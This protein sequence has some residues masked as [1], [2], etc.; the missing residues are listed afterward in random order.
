[1]SYSSELTKE[2]ILLHAKEEFLKKGYNDANLRE[3]ANNAK[4]TTGALY[5]HYKNKEGLFEAIVGK[6]ADELLILFDNAHNAVP[7]NVHFV[8]E[9]NRD[10][11]ASS[12]FLIL[13][14]IYEHLD[15]SR[16][17]FFYSAGTKYESFVDKMIEIEENTSIRALALENFE[18]NEVNRFFIHVMSTSGI[19]N[20]LEAIHHGLSKEHAWDYMEKIQRFY[21]AGVKEILGQ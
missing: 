21:Y 2:R 7:D 15:E 13:D 4:V 3:I 16:L 11:M 18:L 9:T 12:S 5:N 6:T 1:M 8:E 17:I 10:S 19:N 14:Y 20:M